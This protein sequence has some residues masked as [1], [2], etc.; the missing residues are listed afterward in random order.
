ME[1]DNLHAG[2][3]PLSLKS[4]PPADCCWLKREGEDPPSLTNQLQ[5]QQHSMNGS[6]QRGCVQELNGRRGPN[7]IPWAL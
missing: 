3:T 7:R 2:L 5:T 4:V 1:A 6:C